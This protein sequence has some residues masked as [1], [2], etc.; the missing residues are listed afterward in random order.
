MN[1]STT[2]GVR[3][4]IARGSILEAFDDGG[5][6]TTVVANDDSYWGEE[7]DDGYLLVVKRAYSTDREFV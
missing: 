6:A 1:K 4:L 2:P 5:L 7:L 3:R